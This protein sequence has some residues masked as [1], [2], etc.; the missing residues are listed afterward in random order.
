MKNFSMNDLKTTSS[1]SST[2]LWAPAGFY[3]VF[4]TLGLTEPA[5]AYVDPGSGSV[6]IM[7]LLGMLGA[8]SYTLRNYF[9]KIKG[10]FSKKEH[11]EESK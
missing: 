8:I 6:I 10:I 9:Y 7:M 2:R 5:Q 4:V 3:F 11:E 1:I